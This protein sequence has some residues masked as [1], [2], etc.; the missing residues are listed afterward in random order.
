M[1]EVK[2]EEEIVNLEDMWNAVEEEKS[3]SKT[4]KV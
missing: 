4:H 1:K 2:K 3:P